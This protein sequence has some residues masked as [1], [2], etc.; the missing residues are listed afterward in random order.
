MG[1]FCSL[2]VNLLPGLMLL[3]GLSFD[4]CYSCYA[5]MPSLLLP[6][7]PW[8]TFVITP[9][10]YPQTFPLHRNCPSQATHLYSAHTIFV[11]IISAYVLS[12][13]HTFVVRWLLQDNVSLTCTPSVRLRCMEVTGAINKDLRNGSLGFYNIHS[14]SSCGYEVYQGCR[15]SFPSSSLV[16]LS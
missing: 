13:L 9:L 2:S 15:Q 5:E 4:S 8:S 10:R 16:G 3:N 14:T 11:L 6:F 7:V 1:E 12:G